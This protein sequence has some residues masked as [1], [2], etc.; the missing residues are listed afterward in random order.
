MPLFPPSN[1]LP[2]QACT[3]SLSSVSQVPQPSAPPA[4]APALWA[5]CRLTPPLRLSLGTLT[6]SPFLNL[7]WDVCNRCTDSQS[8]EMLS[9]ASG[10]TAFAGNK[11]SGVRGVGRS[12]EAAPGAWRRWGNGVVMM[13]FVGGRGGTGGLHQRQEP[14]SS[15]GQ[16]RGLAG[17]RA[18][19]CAVLPSAVWRLSPHSPGA[20]VVAVS[21]DL[22]PSP[23]SP[24]PIHTLQDPCHTPKSVWLSS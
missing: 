17:N 2:D 4:A 24:P 12:R 16:E 13:S 6:P 21:P 3:S 9:C 11:G 15:Q 10:S 7:T 14:Q 19:G 22:H 18:R 1:F 20:Q 5:S 8:R 23:P